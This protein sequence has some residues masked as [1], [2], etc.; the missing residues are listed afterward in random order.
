MTNEEI[1][2]I[3]LKIKNKEAS[4]EELTAFTK[5]FKE[6]MTDIKDD[7]NEQVNLFDNLKTKQKIYEF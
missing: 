7:L 3:A 6:L 4:P 2:D 1:N 5:A